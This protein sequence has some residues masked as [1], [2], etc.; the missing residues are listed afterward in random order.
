MQ[1]VVKMVGLAAALGAVGIL[2]ACGSSVPKGFVEAAQ[3]RLEVLVPDTWVEGTASGIVDLVRQNADA[4]NDVTLRLAASSDYPDT[5]ARGALGQVQALNVLGTP[6]TSGGL[7]EVAGDRDMWRWDLTTGDGAQHVIAW[8][9]C[10]D[11]EELCVLVTLT[12][13]QAID[14]SLATT[15]QDSITILPPSRG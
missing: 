5:S 8:A 10:V 14:A 6:D 2:S 11:T 4:D 13:E 15:I 7:E 9:L 1:H 12:G 3:G